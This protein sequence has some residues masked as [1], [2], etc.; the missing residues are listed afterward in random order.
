MPEKELRLTGP[1]ITQILRALSALP[2]SEAAHLIHK[3]TYQSS[4]Q[5]EHPPN[6][7]GALLHEEAVKR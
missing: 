1:E 2:Y 3:I 6:S 5:R 7:A 4:I